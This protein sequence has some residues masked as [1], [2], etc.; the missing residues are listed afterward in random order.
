M[1]K[2]GSNLRDFKDHPRINEFITAPKLQVISS[3]G[4]NLG[5]LNR[6]D[7]LMLARQEGLDLIIIADTGAQGVPVAKVGDFGKLLYAK[8]KKQA[9]AKKKQ[10]VIKVKEM[11]FRPKIE[12]HDYQTK[13]KQAIEFLLEGNRVKFTLI[14]RGREAALKASRG[15]EM[16]NKI[17]QT[18]VERGLEHLEKESDMKMGQFWSR[19]YFLKQK[20]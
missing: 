2:Q 12:E 16:F 14:F 13:M 7:A 20:V 11:K 18:L 6:Y 10:K 1:Y 4:E 5:V 9:D 19:V 15:Q 8:K 3:T 17:D